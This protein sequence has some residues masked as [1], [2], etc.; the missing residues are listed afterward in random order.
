MS[1]ANAVKQS[2]YDLKRVDK[3]NLIA[4]WC[5]IA[6]YALTN[7]VTYGLNAFTDV[8]KSIVV[9]GLA[10]GLYYLNLPQFI[11]SLL[12]GLLPLLAMMAYFLIT[13]FDL[14]NHYIAFAAVAMIA[15]YFNERLTLVFGV[16]SN[17]LLIV[18]FLLAGEVFMGPVGND[19]L[20]VEFIKVLVVFNGALALLYFL[21]RWAGELVKNA[22]AE[23]DKVGE[24][25]ARLQTVIAQVETG[26]QNLNNH[27]ET[28]NKTIGATK[29]SSKGIFVSMNEMAKAI[30]EEAS[31]IYKTN[32]AMNSSMDLVSQ[33]QAISGSIAE[34]SKEM[35]QTIE[36]GNEKIAEMV[37]HNEVISKAVG[38]AKATVNELNQSMERVNRAL[39]E[40]L[41]IAEQT[42]M[43]ALNAAIEAARAGEQGKGFA[44]VADEIRKLAEQSKATADNISRIIQELTERSMDTLKKV[45]EGDAAVREGNRIL[46]NITDFF[47]RMKVSV[48]DANRQLF[49][50]VEGTKHV[51]E[52]FIEIQKQIENVAS[53]SEENAASTEEVL[54]TLEDQNNN[55]MQIHEAMANIGRLSRELRGLV[56]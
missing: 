3:V 44:V 40:I 34:K 32:E 31:S 17:V 50:G 13:G 56:S 51:T 28:V 55:I 4:I 25:A 24:L 18:M 6:L 48:E 33:T 9:A 45:Y 15:L 42:N 54:A 41:E 7:I 2:S 39:D 8:I 46:E 30:Q 35:A 36:Q 20:V 49:E 27:I 52:I 23:T 16:I 29:E 22:S 10:T 1:Q 11:K 19:I 5:V 37:A 21:T 47:S 53:I 43:L 26:S 12:F 38:S 14:G